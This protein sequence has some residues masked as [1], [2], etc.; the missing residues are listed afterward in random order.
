VTRALTLAEVAA[1]PAV[2]VQALE[3]VPREPVQQCRKQRPV[4]RGEPHPARA[5]LPLQDQDLVACR[6]WPGRP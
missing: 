6:Q 3:H 4:S 1:L 2:T 5:E